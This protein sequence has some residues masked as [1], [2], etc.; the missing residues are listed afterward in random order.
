MPGREFFSLG[1]EV[2]DQSVALKPFRAGPVVS[3]HDRLHSAQHAGVLPREAVAVAG[4]IAQELHFQG[5]RVTGGQSSGRQ[6]LGDVE[7]VFA[8]GFQSPA[9]QR[10]GLSGVGQHQLFHE[11]FEQFPQPAVEAD[12]FDRHG[13]GPRRAGEVLRDLPATLTG[14]F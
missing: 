2:T 14:S 7:G 3:V 10:P 9:G 11:R 5:R 13:V 6:E 12:R 4:E 8:V 1:L